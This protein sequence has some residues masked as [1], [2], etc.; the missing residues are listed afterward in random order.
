MAEDKKIGGG[1]FR[2]MFGSV[3]DKWQTLDESKLNKDELEAKEL[4]QLIK[5]RWDNHP[6]QGT[7]LNRRAVQRG[8]YEGNQSLSLTRNGGS[9]QVTDYSKPDPRTGRVRHKSKLNV[10][11]PNGRIST[12]K[13]T[14]DEP[15]TFAIPLGTEDND[16]KSARMVNYLLD[17]FYGRVDLDLKGVDHQ[18]LE[19]AYI[20]GTGWYYPKWDPNAFSYSAKSEV[21]E[22]NGDVDIEVKDDHEVFIDPSMKSW[23]KSRWGMTA[24]M[25]P[26]DTVRE[27]AKETNPELADRI[28][29]YGQDPSVDTRYMALG[30]AFEKSPERLKGMCFCLDY[31]ERPSKTYIEGRKMTLVNK[32]IP[33][34]YVPNPYGSFGFLLSLPLIPIYWFKNFDSVYGGSALP[35]QMPLQNEI[36]NFLTLVYNA[37]KKTG[38]NLIAVGKGSNLKGKQIEGMSGLFVETADGKMQPFSAP[39]FPS[40]IQQHI[41]DLIGLNN[42]TVAGIGESA[43]AEI[44]TG[45]SKMSGAALKQLNDAIQARMS[46]QMNSYNAAR[47]V[48]DLFLVNCYKHFVQSE[49]RWMKITGGENQYELKAFDV[50]DLAAGN[51]DLTMKSVAGYSS[52]PAAKIELMINMWDRKIPQAA[53]AGDKAGLKYMEMLEFGQYEDVVQMMKL[54]RDRAEWVLGK[55]LEAEVQ[56]NRDEETDQVTDNLLGVPNLYPTDDKAIHLEVFTLATLKPSFEELPDIKKKAITQRIQLLMGSGMPTPAGPGGDNAGVP[57]PIAPGAQ[58][59]EGG[60]SEGGGNAGMAVSQ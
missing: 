14:K 46:P 31:Y 58:A 8:W 50:A 20:D 44:P 48:R 54:Q 21:V 56:E 1:F 19:N 41:K 16:K 40:Y 30:K 28:S 42:S 6:M 4:A 43:Y 27:M 36:N 53:A 52:S 17:N 24:Y 15:K 60:M 55:I 2:K 35:D 7:E 34:N 10:L 47:Y 18:V 45:G 38:Y 29:E 22:F 5:K 26:V 3:R 13:L 39:T 57:P 51:W 59:A 32:D 37:G 11:K 9:T 33:L 12:S 23:F 25:A 49:K